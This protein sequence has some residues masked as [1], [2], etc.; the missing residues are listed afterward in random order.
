MALQQ[1][2]ELQ[3]EGCLANLL[4]PGNEISMA[5]LTRERLTREEMLRGVMSDDTLHVAPYF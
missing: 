1:T 3:R 4:W 5:H 2:R